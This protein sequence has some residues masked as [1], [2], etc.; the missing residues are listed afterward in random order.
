LRL[1]KWEAG[2]LSF[3]LSLSRR[4]ED[5]EGREGGKRD[6]GGG[7]G[8]KR[9]AQGEEVEELRGPERNP[10]REKRGAML[11]WR[12]RE[13]KER[14]LFSLSL[15]LFAHRHRGLSRV[16]PMSHPVFPLL[17]SSLLRERETKGVDALSAYA[18]V[19]HRG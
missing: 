6:R 8:A 5:G 14:T 2:S 16:S 10:G 9:N 11:L 19:R 17:Y 3:P 15:S 12:T 13:K 4:V 18:R 1:S 7:F